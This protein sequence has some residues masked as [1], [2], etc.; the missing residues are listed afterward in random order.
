MNNNNDFSEKLHYY[1]IWKEANGVW[2]ITKEDNEAAWAAFEQEWEYTK[3]M[4][5]D[6]YSKYASRKYKERMEEHKQMKRNR[7][8]RYIRN[9]VIVI[10][11]AAAILGVAEGIILLKNAHDN[12]MKEIFDENGR[13]RR[14]TWKV[15]ESYLKSS[16]IYSVED[17][18]AIKRYRTPH[19]YFLIN[20]ETGDV[21]KHLYFT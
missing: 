11:S 8:M 14:I 9:G 10:C 6:E 2:P 3:H 13:A 1:R 7:K 19:V 15:E 12:Q 16:I 18:K 5:E 17:G 21:I 4:T 20:K